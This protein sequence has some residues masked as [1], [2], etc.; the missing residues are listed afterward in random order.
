MV[1]SAS[2]FIALFVQFLCER[3]KNNRDF[4]SRHADRWRRYCDQIWSGQYVGFAHVYGS[5]F[6]N[7]VSVLG[8]FNNF[9]WCFVVELVGAA[10][11]GAERNRHGGRVGY[12]SPSEPPA[13]ACARDLPS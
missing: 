10:Y 12:S 11:L 3:K 7:P 8:R 6:F 13:R 5:S 2:T 4:L 1:S 9:A